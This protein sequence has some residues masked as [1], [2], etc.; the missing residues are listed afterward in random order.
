MS[1]TVT[2][3]KGVIVV[4]M[5][6]DNKNIFPPLCQ[7]LWALCCNPVWFKVQKGLMQTKV[8]AALGVRGNVFM[9]KILKFLFVHTYK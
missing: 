8:T 7:I 5:K 9:S 1:V 3:D 4:T 2:K 6:T